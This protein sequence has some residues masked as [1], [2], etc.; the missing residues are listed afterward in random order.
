VPEV[1]G[2][3]V[4]P[5]IRLDWWDTTSNRQRTAVVPEHRV[6]VHASG[7]AGTQQPATGGSAPVPGSVDNMAGSSPELT[8]AVASRWRLASGVFALLWLV[9]LYL[10]LRKPSPVRDKRRVDELPEGEKEL[11]AQLRQACRRGD[12]IAVR[13]ILRHWINKF[14][15]HD[16]DG[17]LLQFAAISED[18]SLTSFFYA[19]DGG[20]FRPGKTGQ[21]GSSD[22]DLNG[23]WK[24]FSAWRKQWHQDVDRSENGFAKL[25]PDVPG[26]E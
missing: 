19:L 9:T 12:A 1:E 8:D 26:S 5:E 14:G 17:S 23:L 21:T 6:Q 15:P 11:L 25:Y 10:A 2:E 20:D 22:I 4:L 16:A 3:L 18:E 7:L 24:A 13:R